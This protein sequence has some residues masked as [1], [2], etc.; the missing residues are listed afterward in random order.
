MRAFMHACVEL[1]AV[2][3]GMHAAVVNDSYYMY[4]A[5][6]MFLCASVT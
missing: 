4:N 1:F 6:R 5:L 2:C 3:G